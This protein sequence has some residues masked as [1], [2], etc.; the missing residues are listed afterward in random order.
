ME[1]RTPTFAEEIACRRGIDKVTALFEAQAT[2]WDKVRN[3]RLAAEQLF[4]RI[5]FPM[6]LL[7]LAAL[8]PKLKMGG[9]LYFYG[10]KGSSS[11]NG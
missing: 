1:L 2:A 8:W 4:Y 3:E 7:L 11:K 9:R 6:C 10:L 5:L